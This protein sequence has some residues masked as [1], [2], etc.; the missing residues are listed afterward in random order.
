VEKIPAGAFYPAPKVD[1]AVVQLDRRP[2]PATPGVT[3]EAFF[4]VAKA[5]FSQPRKQLRNSLAAGLGLAPTAAEAWLTA[6]G[7]APQ[8]RAETL[9][10][11]EWGALA[12]SPVP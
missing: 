4:R 1:S 12:L 7:I 6:A 8:R 9:T 11:S 3:S 10:L 2:E 5:G